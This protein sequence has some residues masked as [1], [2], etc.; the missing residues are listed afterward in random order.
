MDNKRN[1]L[2]KEVAD[3]KLQ[4]MAL[5]VA[6]QLSGDDAPLILIGIRKNGTVI[7]EKI[8]ALLKPYV[9]VP[10][11][12]I[13]VSFDKQ[14]PKEITLTEEPDFTDKSILLIDD[15]TNSGKTLLYAIKPLLNFYPR[16]IQ[17]LVLIERMHKLFPIKPDYVGLSVA[18][19][20]QDHIHVQVSNNEVI[21]AFV[22]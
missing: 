6:E 16:R 17:T 5:E 22:E 15:V 20:M 10:V 14:V 1:I 7:A 11:Q 4:R 21:G 9:Q 19:T 8:G 18:T 3:Q 13:S 2:S 12:I